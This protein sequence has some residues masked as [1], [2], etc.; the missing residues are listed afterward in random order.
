MTGTDHHHRAV[1]LGPGTLG[2]ALGLARQRLGRTARDVAGDLR[3]S[4]QTVR[5]WEQDLTIPRDRDLL[6]YSELLGLD[7]EQLS[8]GVYDRCSTATSRGAGAA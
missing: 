8:P 1:D 7:P 2:E 5:N 4:D 6:A 3:V